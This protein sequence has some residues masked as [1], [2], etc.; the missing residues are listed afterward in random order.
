MRDNASDLVYYMRC[1][2]V[3]YCYYCIAPR[4]TD[5]YLKSRCGTTSFQ[6]RTNTHN[7]NYK[8][9][10][11]K[12]SDNLRPISCDIARAQT[13][14]IIMLYL[15]G[16]SQEPS[17]DN[18]KIKRKINVPKIEIGGTSASVFR[19]FAGRRAIETRVAPFLPTIGP[20]EHRL[21]A[22]HYVVERQG[23]KGTIIGN[24]GEYRYCYAVADT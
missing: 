5:F 24:H 6:V 10:L 2:L 16:Q 14:A 12:A 3:D 18:V 22:G 15:E 23:H 9:Q 1:N 4:D 19:Q 11:Q 20:R 7:G 17:D 8:I 13:D 21:A